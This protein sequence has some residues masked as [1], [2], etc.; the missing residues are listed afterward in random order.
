[1]VGDHGG[2]KLVY[3]YYEEDQTTLDIEDCSPKDQARRI[4]ANTAG[5]AAQHLIA[6]PRYDGGDQWYCD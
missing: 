1:M 2:Q 6:A 4:A 5:I 3:V